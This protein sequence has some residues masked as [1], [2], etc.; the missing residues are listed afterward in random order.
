MKRRAGR[1]RVGVEAPATYTPCPEVRLLSGLCAA[2]PLG[3]YR[4]ALRWVT[5]PGFLSYRL[6]P[7]PNASRLC[8]AR[9]PDFHLHA[10]CTRTYPPSPPPPLPPRGFVLPVNWHPIAAQITME[11]PVGRE[12]VVHPEVRAYINSLVSAVSC[13]RLKTPA[14]LQTLTFYPCPTAGRLQRRR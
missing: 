8:A 5:K 9:L 13:D 14:F 10:P 6:V 2:L 11:P 1:R 4:G 7:S 3:T 12:D